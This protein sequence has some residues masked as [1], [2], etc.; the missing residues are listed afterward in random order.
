MG[1]TGVGGIEVRARAKNSARTEYGFVAGVTAPVLSRFTRVAVRHIGANI[2]PGVRPHL[3]EAVNDRSWL[4]TGAD[5]QRM[6]PY[7]GPAEFCTLPALA[8]AA[9]EERMIRAS[10]VRMGSGCSGDRC[11]I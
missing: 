1:W 9:R 11:A 2:A 6:Q 7:A 3:T 4:K 8:V 10:S 5:N